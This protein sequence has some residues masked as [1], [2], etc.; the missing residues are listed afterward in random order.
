MVILAETVKNMYEYDT[1]KDNVVVGLNFKVC[2][3]VV[4]RRHVVD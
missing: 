3:I 1:L 2:T 4:E